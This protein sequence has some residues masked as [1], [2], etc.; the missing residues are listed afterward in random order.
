[1][2]SFLQLKAQ[3]VKVTKD[4]LDKIALIESSG[5]PSA[6][7]DGGLAVGLYQMHK[8]AWQDAVAYIKLFQPLLYEIGTN[9]GYFKD[10][11]KD[12]LNEYYAEAL[13]LAYFSILQKRYHQQF[14]K[15][16][17]QLQLY[18]M[19]NLGY[20]GA[21]TCDFDPDYPLRTSAR[22]AMKRAKT[23]LNK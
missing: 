11:K 7:G 12:C 14:K 17:T 9:T 16:P 5:N 8:Q 10:F 21:S 19:Y 6:I 18:M 2:F 22:L 23:Y 3:E 15:Y 1:M 4:F 13:A 20:H